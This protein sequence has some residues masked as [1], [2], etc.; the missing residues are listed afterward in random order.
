VPKV[1]VEWKWEEAFDK[2]GFGDGDGLNFT[3]DVVAA[4][5]EFGY[6]CECGGGLHNWR[7]QQVKKASV[8]HLVKGDELYEFGGYPEEEPEDD[9]RKVLPDDVVKFLDEKFKDD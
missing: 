9:P 2:F 4:L 1:I 7:I 3:S 5:A 8:L 6:E